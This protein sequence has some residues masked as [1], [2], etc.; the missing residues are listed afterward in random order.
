[1]V[2]IQHS[3]QPA[4]RADTTTQAHERS[5]LVWWLA[6]ALVVAVLA[7]AG[8]GLW[9]YLDHKSSADQQAA[10]TAVT[11]F[12]A[13]KNASDP[14]AVQAATT[15][16]VIDTGLVNGA[17]NEGPMSGTAFTRRFTRT[18]GPGF[19]MTRV[20]PATMAGDHVIAVPTRV[21]LPKMDNYDKTGIAVYRVE[22]V[23]GTPKIAEVI[24]LPWS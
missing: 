15:S 24:W 20:G 18:L 6:G 19:H 3:A 17:I 21:T 5:S 8:L 11:A 14:D 13:A 7:L 4:Q 16:D 23:N 12:M 1:M 2:D 9:A 10:M 22:D